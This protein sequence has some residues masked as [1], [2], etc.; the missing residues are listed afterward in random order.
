MHVLGCMYS[1]Y[2][3][4]G[5]TYM[6]LHTCV[7]HNIFELTK[8][9]ILYE[10]LGSILL[11][12]LRALKQD[13]APKSILILNTGLVYLT[14]VTSTMHQGDTVTGVSWMEIVSSVI[15]HYVIFYLHFFKLI[16]FYNRFCVVMNF[17]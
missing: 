13:F 10:G 11:T 1:I 9:V 3:W 16:K 2:I 8:N 4:T 6:S 14:T 12:L 15:Q 7:Y 17:L 5:S